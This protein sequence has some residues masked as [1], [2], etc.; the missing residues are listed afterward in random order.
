VLASVTNAH[1]FNP[2]L[3]FVDLIKNQVVAVAVHELAQ[4]GSV[5]DGNAATRQE[6]QRQGRIEDFI[7]DI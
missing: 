2:P 3:R 4:T 5:P 1:D 7:A 6:R